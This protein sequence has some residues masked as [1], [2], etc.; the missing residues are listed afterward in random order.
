LSSESAS[1]ITYPI[2]DDKSELLAK[3]ASVKIICF[4]GDSVFRGMNWSL[5]VVL[6]FCHF[7]HL[8]NF[9]SFSFVRFVTWAATNRLATVQSGPDHG[10]FWRPLK[11][12]DC[13]V[14]KKVG[15]DQCGF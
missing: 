12:P 14:P 9:F 7:S 4:S 3:E 6:S 13:M 1:V 11:M 5:C 15:L 2:W 10:L 8:F